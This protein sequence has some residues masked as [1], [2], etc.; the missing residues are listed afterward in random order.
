MRWHLGDALTGQIGPTIEPVS[1]NF[2][3]PLTGS[4]VGELTLPVPADVADREDLRSLL[5]PVDGRPPRLQVLPRWDDGRWSHWGGPVSKRPTV[6]D[7]GRLLTVEWTDWRGY[8]YTLFR[9]G[10]DYIKGDI[11]QATAF[12]DLLLG[13]VNEAAD[14]E[15]D[16]TAPGT[17][18]FT[19]EQY[20]DTGVSRQVTVRTWDQ[21]I[22]DAVDEKLVRTADGLEWW[23]TIEPLT[24]KTKIRPKVNLAYPQR[25]TIVNPLRLDLDPDG[26]NIIA[27]TPPEWGTPVSRVAAVGEANGPDRLI[28]WDDDP[29]L[30]DGEVL[31]RESVIERSGVVKRATLSDAAADERDKLG[32]PKSMTVTLTGDNPE[33]GTFH[34][35]DRAAVLVDHGWTQ[36][37]VPAAR[38][39]N[40][41]YSGSGQVCLEQTLTLDLVDAYL[42]AD[43]IADI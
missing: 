21:S 10:S 22:A 43:E 12:Y 5:E 30:A 41:D 15:D 40:G 7:D 29:E 25:F 23:S 17:P 28:A 16:R 36:V 18:W 19:V 37:D 20:D 31:L 35:G 4:G 26:G 27:L 33:A 6:S 14:A 8:F 24:D 3:D 34:T 11:E 13:A 39:L 32:Q 2:S 1:W 42:T 38:I 9:R